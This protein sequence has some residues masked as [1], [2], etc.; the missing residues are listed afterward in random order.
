MPF[1]D[2]QSVALSGKAGSNLTVSLSLDVGSAEQATKAKT[3]IDAFVP[4]VKAMAAGMVP[5]LAQKD[6]PSVVSGNAVSLS[7][8]LTEADFPAKE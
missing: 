1:G 7:V 8:E 6:I 4:M 3:A 5:A 2:L